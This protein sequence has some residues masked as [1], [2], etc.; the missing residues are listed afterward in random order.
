MNMRIATHA[1]RL[2]PSGSGWFLASRTSNTAAL[3]TKSGYRSA[4]PNPAAGAYNAESARFRLVTFVIV[5]DVEPGDPSDDRQIV[6]EI[7]V[8]D[9]HF[10][11]RSSNSRS[12]SM[13]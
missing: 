8:L 12:C 9:P 13:I 1:A 5:Y 3:S 2:L 4:S 10:A 11:R 6:S 7:E